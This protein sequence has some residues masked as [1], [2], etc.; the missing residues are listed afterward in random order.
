MWSQVRRV[1]IIGV[2]SLV[3]AACGSGGDA[4]RPTTTDN[5]VAASV[6]PSGTI[7]V[8]LNKSQSISITFGTSDGRSASGLSA[9]GSLASLP[10]GWNGPSGGFEC[11]V[12]GGGATCILELRYLP[13]M[14]ST[15]MLRV[16]FSYRANNG[17]SKQGSVIID[18]SGLA[19][20]LELLAGELGGSGNLDGPATEASFSFPRDVAIDA[21]GTAYVVDLNVVRKITADGMVSTI[22]GARDAS[23]AQDGVG[24]DARFNLPYSAAIGADDML[25]VADSG[26]H[27]IR[28]VT[29]E[30]NTSA[31]AGGSAG[32]SDGIGGSAQFSIPRYVAADAGGNLYV[33]D[34]RRIRKVTPQGVVTT[35]PASALLVAE[36]AAGAL[37]GGLAVDSSG[38]IYISDRNAIRRV[39]P[40]GVVTTF[41]GS[42]NERGHVDGVGTDARFSPPIGFTRD[43][44]IDRSGN[45]Y[46]NDYQT[47]R[48]I[49]PDAVVTTLVGS[50]SGSAD[51]VGTN[52]RFGLP[53]GLGIGSQGALYVTDTGAYNVRK[54]TSEGVVTTFAGR[55]EEWAPARDG[56]GSD[57]RFGYVSDIAIGP[58]GTAFVIDEGSVR[59]VERSGLVTT[60][61][62]GLG[63]PAYF[64]ARGLAVDSGGTLWFTSRQW[65]INSRPPGEYVLIQY[66]TPDGVVTPFGDSSG[67]PYSLGTIPPP[68]YA[69]DI[70]V[71][72]DGVLY[73][74]MTDS[75]LRTISPD[76]SANTLAGSGYGYSDGI[77][78]A[79][80][81]AGDTGSVALDGQGN[82]Y[83][84]DCGNHAVRKVTPAGIVTTIAGD[85]QSEGF[86]DGVG[87]A[88]R[89]RCPLGIAV[90]TGG[91]VYVSDSATIR[92]I[93]PDSTVTTVI[94]TPPYFGQRLGPLPA[95]LQF[96]N[97]VA[98]TEDGQLIIT[99]RKA[100]LI[101]RGL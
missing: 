81:F 58:D 22:A 25:Y 77:G 33:T 32:T 12:V 30:G 16:E 69:R 14:P 79:A 26:N 4:D 65:N 64:S 71:S 92:R 74:R 29:P 49:T 99:D 11:P 40:D 89:F 44:V 28:R 62:S 70:A 57:A 80:K 46:V 96:P 38:V 20:T 63:P 7:S 3:V 100:I 68:P 50:P 98:V 24:S 97:G 54:V 18:Y 72:R 82:A 78:A 17:V 37:L 53:T 84:A 34:G 41:A 27:S 1:L 31:F 19:P 35:H 73:L 47:I 5:T 59:K 94:G 55:S 90:D 39:M 91:T 9:T 101:T 43:M 83:V 76:R 86:A 23:G 45:L 15:G 52:A 60:L 8:Y 75:T 21:S 95:S 85:A 66:M 10:A 51:G 36:D 6:A 61:P 13:T 87:A 48:K 88:A 56:I 93:T 2:A 42:V 67:Q